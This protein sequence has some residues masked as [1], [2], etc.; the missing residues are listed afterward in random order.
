[1][2]SGY[3]NDANVPIPSIDPADPDPIIVATKPS[4]EL[5][6]NIDVY[7]VGY[8]DDID[9]INVGEMD[10]SLLGIIVD[11]RDGDEVLVISIDR[12]Q[13][14]ANSDTYRLSLPLLNA[15]PYGRLNEAYVC[16][17]SSVDNDPDPANVDTMYDPLLIIRIM[18][19]LVSDT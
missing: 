14:P 16:N 12:I 8:S 18:L 9:G 15:M 3:I 11:A 5:D 17:P 13:A 2:P 6:V 19:F 1:M 7:V 4:I 10:G